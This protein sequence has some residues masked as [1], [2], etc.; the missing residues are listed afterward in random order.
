MSALCSAA[1]RQTNP[2]LAEPLALTGT[3]HYREHIY[4]W[5]IWGWFHR[6]AFIF[7]QLAGTA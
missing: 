5:G 4:D 7:C 2:D 6:R 3:P 1:C